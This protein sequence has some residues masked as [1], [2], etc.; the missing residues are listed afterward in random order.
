MRKGR[1]HTATTKRKMSQA[2]R[3]RWANPRA[4]EIFSV[5]LRH[6]WQ[7]LSTAEQRK[8]TARRHSPEAERKRAVTVRQIWANPVKKEA[9]LKQVN[10]PT[11]NRKRSRTLKKAYASGERKPFGSQPPYRRGWLQ[12]KKA[13]R[14]YCHSSWERIRAKYFDQDPDVVSFS[15]DTFVVKY[16]FRGRVHSCFVDFLI[17]YADG[18]RVVEEIKGRTDGRLWLA[19][20]CAIQKAC[21][22]AGYQFRLLTKLVELER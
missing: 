21:K 12:T 1:K 13:G 11:A 3:E 16:I 4:R 10:T 8:R 7:R 20:Q 9:W 22:R 17:V 15:K 14:I 2:S 6:C 19:K 5:A 18:T